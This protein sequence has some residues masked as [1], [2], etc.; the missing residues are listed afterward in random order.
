MIHGYIWKSRYTKKKAKR[1]FLLSVQNNSSPEVLQKVE[2]FQD[3]YTDAQCFM[4]FPRWLSGKESTCQRRRCSFN[5]W[6]RK[7]PWWRKWK[8]SPV[9][10]P[11]KSHAQRNVVNYSP[12]GLKRVGHDLMTKQQQCFMLI[13]P[14]FS[15]KANSN[16]YRINKL[17]LWRTRFSRNRQ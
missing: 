1:D 8:P 5:P 16:R 6:V 14:Q 7:I 9:F 11:G 17:K 10:S 13:F 3:M 4:G 2:L 12:W 15:S